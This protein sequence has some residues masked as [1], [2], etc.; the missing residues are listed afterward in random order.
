MKIFVTRGKKMIRHS[1]ASSRGEGRIYLL[2]KG[3]HDRVSLE[4]K[5]EQFV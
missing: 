4:R 5:L 3:G 1:D 2:Y